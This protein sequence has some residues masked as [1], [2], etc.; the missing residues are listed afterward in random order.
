MRKQVDICFKVTTFEFG[1]VWI[2]DDKI[3]SLKEDLEDDAYAQEMYDSSNLNEMRTEQDL[4]V[5]YI[6]AELGEGVTEELYAR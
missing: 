2:D 6:H 4:V 1:T 5:D 3:D